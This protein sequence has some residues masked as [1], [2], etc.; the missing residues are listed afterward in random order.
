MK[1]SKFKVC[2]V[3]AL[4]MALVSGFSLPAFAA[5]SLDIRHDPIGPVLGGPNGPIPS[6]MFPAAPEDKYSETG[7]WFWNLG[8]VKDPRSYEYRTHEF[9]D[10]QY[11]YGGSEKWNTKARSRPVSPTIPHGGKVNLN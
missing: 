2:F 1:T 8:D 3:L 5:P 4:A 7:Q 11:K 9:Y 6:D 10:N